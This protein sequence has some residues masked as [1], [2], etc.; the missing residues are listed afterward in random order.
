MTD[1][2]GRVTRCLVTRIT[3]RNKI[4]RKSSVVNHG[5]G[6]CPPLAKIKWLQPLDPNG[7]DVVNRPC[8]VFLSLLFR[9][10]LPLIRFHAL[11]F[12][13]IRYELRYFSCRGWIL[14]SPFFL[15]FPFSFSLISVACNG[16]WLN[17]EHRK[18]APC[19]DG[20]T[21]SSFIILSNS[22]DL[23]NIAVCF[24]NASSS[25]YHYYYL[26]NML[27]DTKCRKS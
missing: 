19:I 15:S 24:P 4:T 7:P 16:E 13:S 27:H 26:T 17:Y 23:K 5:R 12:Y 3:R 18:I 22:V 25:Y 10:V 6:S 8:S 11:Y 2:P 9:R 14:D 21:F 1:V 20:D